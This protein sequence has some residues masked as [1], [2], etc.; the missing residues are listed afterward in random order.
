MAADAPAVFPAATRG[1][2]TTRRDRRPRRRL[3]EGRR[4][5]SRRPTRRTSSR[6][7]CL[8][9]HGTRLR[10]GRRQA[11]RVDL[12]AGRAFRARR[13]SRKASASR[14]PTSTSSPST[15]AAASAASSRR[16]RRGS[17]AP[18]W[19]KPAKRA[20]EADARPQGRASR[21]RQPAVGDRAH[22]RRRRPTTAC[23]PRSTARAGAP[24]APARGAD[25]PLPVHLR[26][27]EP[28][29]THKDVFIN[30]GQQR[31]MR[32][33]GHP[34]GCF[35]TEILMDELADRVEDRSARVPHEEP[36]ARRRRTRC[37]REYFARGAKAFGWD[38]RHPT[39]DPTPRARSRPAWACRAHR[40]GG[41]GRGIA[42]ALRRS[43]PTAAS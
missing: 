26:L 12:D 41:G 39:G 2:A 5:S 14:R 1:K 43:R 24:A 23:S 34:Q 15:W 20:G 35:L 36:A 16:T 25:F 38:K 10:V 8:E 4:T 30:A 21:H 29:R 6:H 27:P 13:D 9:T 42:G 17:S 33:P 11:H 3:R 22:P 37:G 19:R 32:A 28:P 31:A 7:V 18:S 40:W